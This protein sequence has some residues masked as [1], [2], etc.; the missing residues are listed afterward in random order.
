MN[1]WASRWLPVGGYGL[2]VRTDG[3]NIRMR[4]CVFAHRDEFR[5]RINLVGGI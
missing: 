3:A 1:P 2:A 4:C 5:E